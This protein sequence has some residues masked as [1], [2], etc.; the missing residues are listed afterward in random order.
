MASY[1]FFITVALKYILKSEMAV[2]LLLV[3][4]SPSLPQDCVGYLLNLRIFFHIPMTN[5]GGTWMEAAL[6]LYV[7]FGRMVIFHNIN[8]TNLWAKDVFSF[9]SIFPNLFLQKFEVFT[10]EAFYLLS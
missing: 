9:S 7:A 5:V 2:P 10:T 4:C 6:S 1:W 8:S 3:G